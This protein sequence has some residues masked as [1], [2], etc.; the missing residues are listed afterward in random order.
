M[1]PAIDR[2]DTDILIL[3]QAVPDCLP[4]F[5]PSRVRR[6]AQGSPWRSKG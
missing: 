5:M 2:H 3:D 6:K 4:R 1:T